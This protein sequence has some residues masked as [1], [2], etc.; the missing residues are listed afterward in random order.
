MEFKYTAQDKNGKRITSQAKALSV[1][2]LISQ[3]K[4]QGLLPL[5]IKEV[6]VN[7]KK[8]R[9]Q[10]S[11]LFQRRVKLK[12]LVVFTRQLSS[13]LN[14]GLILTESLETI[15]ND[16]ENHYLRNV[17]E[18]L[19]SHIRSGSSFS[20]A[21]LKYPAVFP[22]NYIAVVKSGEESGNLGKTLADL[23]K[24]LEDVERLTQKIKSAIHYPLFL[25]GFC[26]FIVSV[27]VFFIIPKFRLIYSQ[28][29][30]ELPTFTKIVINISEISLKNAPWA[31]LTLA[32]FTISFIFLLRLPRFR[33]AFDYF[34]LKLFIFGKIIKKALIARFCRTLSILLSGGV[35]LVTAL[36]ISCDVT[37]NF[38]LRKVID[39]IRNDVLSG[40]SFSVALKQEGVFPHMVVKMVQVGEK[41]GKLSDMLKHNAEYY[42]QELEAT[43]NAFTSLIEPILIVFIGCIVGTVVVAFYLPIFRISSLIH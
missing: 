30:I 42:D 43:I 31:I 13:T 9:A 16:L 7:G 27:I 38:Y 15:S 28:A 10:K 5:Q 40:S 29:R 41:T 34:K 39:K 18:G 22:N 35:G 21:L 14:S 36:P 1:S 11:Y 32:I 4:N 23:T 25:I 17:I 3:L 6:K 20:N 37:N 12:E 33:L 19:I 24:Y 8:N 2:V 26:I